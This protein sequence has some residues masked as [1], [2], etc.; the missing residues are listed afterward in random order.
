MSDVGTYDLEAVYDA[1]IA[2]LMTQ[3]LAICKRERMPM[4]ASFAYAVTEDGVNKCT[5]YMNFN[6]RLIREF[7]DAHDAVR[8]RHDFMALTITTVPK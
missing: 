8:N 3:I 4:V 7:K 6:G 1:E 5:S 2:P